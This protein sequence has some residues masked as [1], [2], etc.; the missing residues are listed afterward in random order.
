MIEIPGSARHVFRFDLAC[1]GNVRVLKLKNQT[2]SNTGLKP[3]ISPCIILITGAPLGVLF[4]DSLLCTIGKHIPRKTLVHV[5]G[6]TSLI[7]DFFYAQSTVMFNSRTRYRVKERI[8][9]Y[10][11]IVF[12]YTPLLLLYFL[13]WWT[14]QKFNKVQQLTIIVIAL[15]ASMNSDVSGV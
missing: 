2:S 1:F 14:S 5:S 7:L 9:L 15:C 13:C 12:L 8:Y 6:W 10:Y 11:I 3:Y 4:Q